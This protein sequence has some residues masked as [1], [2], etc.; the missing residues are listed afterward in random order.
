MTDKYN[1]DNPEHQKIRHEIELGDAIPEIRT[2]QRATEGLKAVGFEILHSEDLAARED[3]LPWYYPL[4][5]NLADVQTVWDYLTMLRI[6]RAG[7]AVTQV[8][9]KAMEAVGLAPKGTFAVSQSLEIAAEALVVGGTTGVF[10]P[11]QMVCE[12]CL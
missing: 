10:T 3:H 2:I 9:V 6:T 5:G 8:A 7:R 11:M 4:R 1:K 12:T